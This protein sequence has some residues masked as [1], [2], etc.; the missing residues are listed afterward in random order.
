MPVNMTCKTNGDKL[1]IEVDLKQDF[2][3]SKSGKTT[4]IASSLGAE[5]VAHKGRTVYVN[6]NVYRK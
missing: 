6:L 2:G 4:I 3:K 1:T 5:L